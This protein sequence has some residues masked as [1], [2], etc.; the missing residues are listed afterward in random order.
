MYYADEQ[1]NEIINTYLASASVDSTVRIWSRHSDYKNDLTSKFV[2]EQVIVSKQNGFALALKFYILPISNC[3]LNLIF[4][5]FLNLTIVT[6][7][8]QLI[9]KGVFI[10]I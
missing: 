7:C 4:Y 3:K 8:F 10:F 1:S 9:F 6:L 2:Q 5:L